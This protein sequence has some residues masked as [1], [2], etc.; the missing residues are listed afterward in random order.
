MFFYNFFQIA[1]LKFN[2]IKN[3][4]KENLFYSKVLKYKEILFFI[5]YTLLSITNASIY[6]LTNKIYPKKEKGTQSNEI[7]SQ[8]NE[9]KRLKKK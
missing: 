8:N 7:K 3:I 1:N 2:S 5:A 4:I 6:S 9:I